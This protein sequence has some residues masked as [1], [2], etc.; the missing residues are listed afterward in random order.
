MSG[1]TSPYPLEADDFPIDPAPPTYSVGMQHEPD[2]TI[3]RVHRSPTFNGIPVRCD[4]YLHNDEVRC[5]LA[6]GHV[7]MHKTAQQM[8]LEADPALGV[9]SHPN[10]WRCNMCGGGL[11]GGTK[12]NYWGHRCWGA[13]AP[14]DPHE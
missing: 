11:S 3:V 8:A 5:C 14:E 1:F 7:N 10:E 4:A 2:G 13:W 12:I 9:T 6:A